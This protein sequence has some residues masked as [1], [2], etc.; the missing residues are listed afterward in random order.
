MDKSQELW[1][2]LD[3]RGLVL[4]S[5]HSGTD[6]DAAKSLSGN[7]L[8]T[9]GHTITK[10]ADRYL[11]HILSLV[12]LNRI[13]AVN[14]AGNEY[15]KA[16]LPTYKGKR[17][18]VDPEMRQC[19][20]ASS[21]AVRQLLH[22]L[23]IVQVSLAGTEADDVIAY[24]DGNLPGRKIVYT[25]DGD[26]IALASDTTDVFLKGEPHKVF[27]KGELEVQPHHLTLFKS[28]V[29]DTSDNYVGVKG[30]GPVTWCNLVKEYGDDGI[31]E[32]ID[33]AQS[34]DF[35]R[36]KRILDLQP[37]QHPLL[38]KIQDGLSEWRTAWEVAKLHP[39]LVDQRWGK[40]FR[41]LRWEKRVPSRERLQALCDDTASPYLMQDFAAYLPS[42][43]LIQAK[44]WD[45][46]VLDEAEELFKQSRFIS[47][48]WETFSECSENFEKAS[49]GD[50]VD[51]YGSQITSAG[52]TCGDNLQHTF[53]FT[54]DHADSENNI[55]KENLVKLLQRIP[56]ETPVIAHNVMFEAAVAKADLGYDLFGNHTL[57]D[58]KVMASHVAEAD[59]NGLKDLSQRWLRY[60]QTKYSDVIERGKTMRD[61]TGEHV[62]KYGADDAIVTAHLYDLFYTI[63]CLEGTWEFVRDNEFPAIAVL[64]EAHLAGAS[65]DWPEVER[66][67]QEDAETFRSNLEQ[68][69][70]LLKDNQTPE[71]IE[72]G[73]AAWCQELELNFDGDT[74]ALLAEVKALSVAA[75][76]MAE[77]KAHRKLW[78]MLKDCLDADSTIPDIIEAFTAERRNGRIK[79]L[80]EARKAVK[81]EDY[82]EAA[83]DPAFSWLPIKISAVAK[84]YG[85]P[86]DLAKIEGLP[87]F[88]EWL[89]PLA[90][91]DVA[92][93]FRADLQ[94]VLENAKDRSTRPAYWRIR[95][96]YKAVSEGSMVKS[97]TELNLN[98]PLQ[99]QVLFYGTL[100]LPIRLR[101]FEVSES[102]QRR[103]LPGSPQT[104]VDVIA[105]AIGYGDAAEGSWQRQVLELLLEA[106]KADTRIKLFYN[107]LPL[108]K[109]PKDGLIHPQ[110]NSVGTETRRPSGSSP[111]LLQLSKKKEGVKVRRCFLPNQKLGHDLVVSIDWAAQELRVIADLSKDGTMLAC[112]LG[113]NLLDVHSVTAAQIMKISY[114]DFMKGLKSPEPLVSK[115][116]KEARTAAK[117]T[118][119]GS[120]YGIG[121][122]KLSRS[123]VCEEETAK[124]YLTAKKRAYPG[125]EIWKARAKED[126]HRKGYIQTLFGTRKH[127]FNNLLGNDE[128]LVGYYERSSI[129]QLV[130]GVCADYLKKVL[131]DLHRDQTFPRHGAVLVAPIYDELVMS[132]HSSQA[133]SLIHEVYKVM[134]QGIPGMSIPMLANPSLGLNFA[135]QV[136]VLEDENQELTSGL[137][138]AAIDKALGK[139]EQQEAA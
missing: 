11:H 75:N 25:V 97:G 107:K 134:T 35:T 87:A 102:R 109:H 130:Q 121:A 60:T 18:E 29:G 37:G 43:Y 128:G 58:T 72:A 36:V 74:R 32:L 81:Y 123:L 138:Q 38:Q 12:P 69:R 133:V 114:Q 59:T 45:E 124:E 95:D 2:L 71:T 7:T 79:L 3:L 65:I 78:P 67:H 42:Q 103:G 64:V 98:S 104:D 99:M 91:T 26:L 22:S 8:P 135:D 19:L 115:I 6:Q 70:Q 111:N 47:L 51:M 53:F 40:E 101:A 17:A 76:P 106:K 27:K 84:S 4:H 54:F 94:D 49:T 137:I 55:P 61:Y 1:F 131:A 120:A 82:L 63:L 16:I 113:D 15:R 24:L 129:N 110:F 13:I 62:F 31:A 127:V 108:W 119:F 96:R 57:F 46:S 126:L 56:K 139:V 83:K 39:E 118:N 117:E 100:Q 86:S 122:A 90:T 52:I 20:E 30:F 28:L 48:D 136:E 105:A 44:D 68:I 14:D 9:P 89:E 50:Y 10:F 132:C 34:Q 23:G 92:R 125:V 88:I 33:I 93:Q 77:V 73:A 5:L 66:Q 112:Y 80:S 85:L 116:F 41:R 21:E